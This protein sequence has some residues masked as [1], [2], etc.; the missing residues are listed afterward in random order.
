EWDAIGEPIIF[1]FQDATQNHPPRHDESNQEYAG[2]ER[3]K[4][5]HGL[6]SET[7]HKLDRKQIQKTVNKA[8][9]S[10]LGHSVFSGLMYHHLFPDT[11]KTGSLGKHRNKA[12]HFPINFNAL[13]HFSLVSLES[14]VHIMQWD[15][16]YPSIDPIV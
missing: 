2:A 10:K 8:L 16:R 11:V 1:S 12:V 14:A 7:T 4:K 3:P 13:H 9:P 6:F 5:M 15:T